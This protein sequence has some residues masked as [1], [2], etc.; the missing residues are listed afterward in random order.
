M[1]PMLS[2]TAE[3]V[4]ETLNESDASVFEQTWYQLPLPDDARCCVS[5]GRNCAHCVGRV[6][7]E[8]EKLRVRGKI[9]SSLAGEVDLTRNGAKSTVASCTR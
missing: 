3:E 7:K 9:G 8:L 6:Q 5:A 2:F 4:W 1:A